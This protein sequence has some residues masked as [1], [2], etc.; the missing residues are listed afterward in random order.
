M[1]RVDLSDPAVFHNNYRTNVLRL[2]GA[3]D[4]LPSPNRP[5]NHNLANRYND[6]M[7]D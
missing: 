6:T 5:N 2:K 1:P 3:L 7:E 4:R